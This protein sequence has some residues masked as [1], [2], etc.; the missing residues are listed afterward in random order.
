[1]PI[2]PLSKLSR[3]VRDGLAYLKTQPDVA[4]AEVFASA[5]GNLTVRLNYTSRIPSNAVEEP[6][7]LESFGL[8][9]R[10]ALNTPQGLK[11]GFG[12]EPTDLSVEGVKRALEKARV[13]AVLDAEYVSLPKLTGTILKRVRYHDPAVM[14]VGNGRM[15]QAGWSTVESALE[16]FSTS[17]DLLNVAGS[18]EG[19]RDLGLILGGDVVMLQERM[20]IA[21][22]H[23]PR[24]QT[25][26]STLV[27]AFTTAMLEDQHAKGSSWAV[28][29]RLSDLT[30][31]P[32]AEA[33]RN[34]V[35]S[36]AG[37]RVPGGAHRVILGPQPLAEL[38]E[39]VLMPSLTLDIFYAEASTFMGKMGKRVA[40]PTLHLYDHGAAPGL[41]ASKSITDEGL[42]T[43]RT[44]L[45][46]DGELV[47]LLA[48]Y[49]EYERI[50]RD[51]KGSEKLGVDPAQISQAIA[52]RNGFRTGRGGGRNFDSPP[53]TTPTN[54][55]V[56]GTEPYTREELFRL[57]GDGLYIGRIWYTYPVNGIGPGDF[58]GTVVGDSYLIR[59]GRLAAPI[60][61]NT[62][63]MNENLHNMLNNILGV[64]SSRRGTVRWASDQVVWAPEVAVADFHLNEIGG[65]MEEVF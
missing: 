64:G 31:A 21:S 14:R 52:P 13:G 9:V 6:K 38:L 25:D 37:E 57:V 17:E 47:G 51:P 56:E 12:S 18:P 36:M 29:N 59:D 58:S 45:I 40:S 55:V 46:R 61:P 60:K 19:V 49:Y 32:G 26:E 16:V 30:G 2:T 23:I 10:V 48:N 63:R 50:L 65:Y 39:W 3:A 44:D 11:T 7:S 28:G 15:V 8:S 24:V 1:M 22:T 34:A 20:A 41:A 54:L 35:R 33:A 53:G 27:M 5:N 43:G 42:P 4:E 62:L